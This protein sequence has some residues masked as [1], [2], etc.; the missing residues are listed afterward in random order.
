M[1]KI[2]T[3]LWIRNNKHPRMLFLGSVISI[4]LMY[5]NNFPNSICFFLSL[6]IPNAWCIHK[7]NQIIGDDSDGQSNDDDDALMVPRKEDSFFWYLFMHVGVSLSLSPF[8]RTYVSVKK[9]TFYLSTVW[10]EKP[11]MYLH[12]TNPTYQLET[13]PNSNL[14]Q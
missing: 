3:Y 4:L 2:N 10:A 14:H 5:Q 12:E 8:V 7:T 6:I 1:N 9:I 13:I 11:N